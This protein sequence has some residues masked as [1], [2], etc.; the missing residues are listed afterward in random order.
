[1]QELAP[2]AGSDQQMGFAL[3]DRHDR[4]RFAMSVDTPAVIGSEG[5]QK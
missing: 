2:A 3:P 4:V 1:M 5:K